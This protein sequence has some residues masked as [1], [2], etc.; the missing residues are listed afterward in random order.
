MLMAGCAGPAPPGRPAAFPSAAVSFDGRYEGTMR[1]TGASVGMDHRDCATPPRISIEVKNNR[2]SL[3][4]PHPQVAASTPSLAD[5]A[6]PVY[7]AAIRPD[8]TVVGISHQT[9]TALQGVVS[10][11][12][13]SGQVYGLL[14]YYEFTADRV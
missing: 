13:M 3:A 12:R 4:T 1:V 7:D 11:T 9:N 5:R 14:C 2:F 8:G 10:G 6:A